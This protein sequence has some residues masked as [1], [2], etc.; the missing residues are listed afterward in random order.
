MEFCDIYYSEKPVEALKSRSRRSCHTIC[1]ASGLYTFTRLFRVDG[2]YTDDQRQM[3]L[4]TAVNET[5][6]RVPLLAGISDVYLRKR[7]SVESCHNGKEDFEIGKANVLRDGTD[8]TFAVCGTLLPQAL[9]ASEQLSK[10]GIYASVV[11]F[12]TLKPFVQDTLVSF[13]KKQMRLLQ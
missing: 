3:I 7:D 1:F 11:E 6:N 4:E 8:V 9:Q 13:A 2:A 12:H 10:A 5:N